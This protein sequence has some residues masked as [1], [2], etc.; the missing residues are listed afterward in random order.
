MVI[1]WLNVLELPFIPFVP[2]TII[3]NKLLLPMRWAVVET[4]DA[5]EDAL[6]GE[7][8][9]NLSGGFHH[10]SPNSE[11]GFCIY[12]DI[13]PKG[14]F[15]KNRVDIAVP[16]HTG[17]SGNEYLEYLRS[18]EKIKSVFRMAIVI[19]GT[20]VLAADPLGGFNLSIEDVVR[21]DNMIFEKLE[22]L[23]ISTVFLSGGGYSKDSARAI[24]QRITKLC[25]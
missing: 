21:R 9:W 11:E 3:D 19:S 18:R 7:N 13:Y 14:E 8:C 24:A 6:S 1:V 23:S 2:F 12:N 10:A 20:D 15:T 5:M 17:T 22:K 25:A 16:L 4:I